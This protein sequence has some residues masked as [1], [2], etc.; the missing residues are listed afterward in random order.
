MQEG[1]ETV[2]RMDNIN[3]ISKLKTQCRHELEPIERFM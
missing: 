1:D 3:A 2:E